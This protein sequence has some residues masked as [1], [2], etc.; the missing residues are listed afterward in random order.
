MHWVGP[1]FDPESTQHEP[2]LF[3]KHKRPYEKRDVTFSENKGACQENTRPEPKFGTT[4]R[5]LGDIYKTY[6][7]DFQLAK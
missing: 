1:M 6:K 3:Q 7:N 5:M 2:G 4:K